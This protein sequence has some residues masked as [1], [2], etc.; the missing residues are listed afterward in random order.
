MRWLTFVV[1]VYSTVSFPIDGGSIDLVVALSIVGAALSPT[2]S[3]STCGSRPSSTLKRLMVGGVDRVFDIG[4]D[5]RNEGADA[6]Q[7]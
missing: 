1:D 6:T 3:I 7:P 2:I 5:F 4:R